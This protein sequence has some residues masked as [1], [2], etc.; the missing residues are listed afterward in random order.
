VKDSIQY[1]EVSEEEKVLKALA[2]T[3]ESGFSTALKTLTPKTPSSSCVRIEK[4]SLQ[5]VLK[6][7]P[8]PAYA[9]EIR[10]Q[11][12]LMGNA[13]LVCKSSDLVSLGELLAGT[14]AKIGDT[15][16]PELMEV[17][18][19]FFALA[20]GESCRLFS[21]QRF[22]IASDGPEL[23]NPDGK[24]AS[25][26]PLSLSYE[27]V[28][29]AIFQ[30]SVEP[31]PDCSFHFLADSQLLESL[32]TMLP[33]Y[34]PN[35]KLQS[36]AEQQ[37]AAR[38]QKPEESFGYVPPG[39]ETSPLKS[40]GTGTEKSEGTW[41]IDLILDVELPVAVSFGD[42]EMPL[43]DVL[44]LAAGSVIELDKSVNDPVTVIVNQKPI[45]RGEVVMVD[46][47][48]GVRITEVESTVERIRSLA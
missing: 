40:P 6:S 25:L 41:N 22:P 37:P 39:G 12:G 31:K 16:S 47:N 35:P 45:A 42:C 15:L 9:L 2:V 8:M 17:C 13:L 1:I 26:G 23:I 29:C 44:K 46:G 7:S 10:Y 28:I 3:L 24:A 33:N 5:A 43:R 20:V 21:A 36:G 14:V 19:R 34:D 38:K 30:V 27:G 18:V 48:Y 4:T 11:T 32:M